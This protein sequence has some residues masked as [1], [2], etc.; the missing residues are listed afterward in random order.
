MQASR[1]DAG[2]AAVSTGSDREALVEGSEPMSTNIVPSNALGGAATELQ[3]RPGRESMEHALLAVQEQLARVEE[4][5][6]GTLCNII[7]F[8]CLYLWTSVT[9]ILVAS[10]CA[11]NSMLADALL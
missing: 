3:A 6:R 1:S 5:V 10:T 9:L 11:S 8:A 7:A 4:Q 2:V